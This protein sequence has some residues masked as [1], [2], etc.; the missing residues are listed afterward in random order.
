MSTPFAFIG[1][2]G[3]PEILI[4]LAIVVLIFGARKLPELGR[5]V[6]ESIKNFRTAMRSTEDDAGN[7]PPSNDTAKTP[8]RRSS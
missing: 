6:G 8:E 4:I 1:S 7:A 3:L 5:G 2:L